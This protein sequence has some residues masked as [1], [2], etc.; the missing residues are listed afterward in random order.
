L[1]IFV[2]PWDAQR[3]LGAVVDEVEESAFLLPQCPVLRK[4]AARLA[5]HPD[6]R[7]VAALASEHCK[8]RLVRL[9]AYLFAR[10]RRHPFSPLLYI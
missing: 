2:P 5:H 1:T 8:Q 9:D 7:R 4:I 10:L 3:Y 6:G